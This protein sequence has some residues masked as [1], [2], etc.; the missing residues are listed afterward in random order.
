MDSTWKQQQLC[1]QP[2]AWAGCEPTRGHSARQAAE[3][4]ASLL[5]TPC[6]NSS[7]PTWPYVANKE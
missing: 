3:Q 6:R 2:T 5:Q 7:M 1:H 4:G